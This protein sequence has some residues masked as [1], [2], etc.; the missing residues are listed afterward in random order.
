MKKILSVANFP[1]EFINCFKNMPKVGVNMDKP[2]EKQK[3]KK[4]PPPE[5]K[6]D[7]SRFKS[8]FQSILMVI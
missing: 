4:S 6:Y 5:A 2:A 1:A 8:S 7:V 3:K